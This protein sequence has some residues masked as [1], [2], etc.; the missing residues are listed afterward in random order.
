MSDSEY[1]YFLNGEQAGAVSAKDRGLT[2]GHGLFETV[3]L[4]NGSLPL[5]R[6]HLSRIISGADRL[7]LV[8]DQLLLQ[9]YIDQLLLAS[10]DNGIIKIIVT[11]GSEGRGYACGSS[12]HLSYILQWFPFLDHSSSYRRQG[13]SLKYCEHRLPHSPALAGIKHLNRLDQVMARAEWQDNFPEGLM[14]D[15]QGDVIEGVSSN[16]FM[17]QDGWWLTPYLNQ[18]GVAG[19]MRQYLIDELLPRSSFQIKEANISVDQLISADEVFVCNSVIGIWPVVTLEGRGRWSLGK[20]TL[21][22]QENLYEAL[23][24]FG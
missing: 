14:R 13:I 10:P 6:Y 8:I 19:V 16:L 4:V 3:R 18:C 11:A 24:C 12:V 1:L 15:E 7:G 5:L 9:Q 20:N 23:P 22:I 21:Q 2:Y 17:F